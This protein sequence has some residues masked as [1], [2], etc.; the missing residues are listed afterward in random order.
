[1]TKTESP[2][3]K[4]SATERDASDVAATETF[5]P[6]RFPTFVQPFL[7]SFS[8]LSEATFRA[9]WFGLIVYVFGWKI[10]ETTLAWLVWTLTEDPFMLG[11]YYAVNGVPLILFQLFGGVI[12]DRVDRLRL[13]I[14]TQ[15]MTATVIAA[16]AA[17]TVT[18]L[19][20]IWMILTLAFFSGTFRAFEQP[21]RMAL[22]PSIVSRRNLPNAI[23]IGSMPWQ[24]GRFIGPAIA[25]LMIWL[26]G[27]G[28]GLL[29]A[30]AA[31]FLAIFLYSRMRI[32]TRV[33]AVK[34][35]MLRNFLVGVSFVR[36]NSLFS[37]LMLLTFFNSLLGMSYVTMLPAFA[38]A[39]LQSGAQGFGFLSAASGIGAILGTVVLA[40]V[41]N[42][43][44]HRGVIMLVGAIT[45]GILLA[46]FS[47]SP[48]FLMA[49]PLIFLMGAANT[50]YITT[51]N[52]VLQQQVPDELRGRVMGIFG[53]CWNL[54]PLGGI[55]AGA[56]A[57]AY[58]TR[59]AL[60]LGGI[61][62]VATSI[63]LFAAVP[64]FRRIE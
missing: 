11:I 61:M 5:A 1:M 7:R 4:K 16:A 2:D 26:F 14:G 19:I 6:N 38:D 30:A 47:R 52:I 59:L 20:E 62:V 64:R 8:S 42:R 28:A 34:E 55:L 15:L 63:L 44:R 21:T 53:L 60:L 50:I 46:L 29:V 22:I 27:P 31:Y 10:E 48:I 36:H 58:D 24:S 12:A 17:L 45:F 54:I 13:L 33:I 39:E 35:S 57:S 40:N 32:E 51:V 9:Y 3:A 37:T 18:G 56:V 41:A 43:M 23:T 49:A 25:G